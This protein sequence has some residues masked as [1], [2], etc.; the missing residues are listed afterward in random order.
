MFQR[1]I[2]LCHQ[3]DDHD[4]GDSKHL[5]NTG[6][7]QDYTVLYFRRLSLSYLP[8]WEPEIWQFKNK[9]N[10]CT[11]KKWKVKRLR[12]FILEYQNLVTRPFPWLTNYGFSVPGPFQNK[13]HQRGLISLHCS[14]SIWSWCKLLHM[15]QAQNATFWWLQNFSSSIW[16]MWNNM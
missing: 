15:H 6:L 3:G 11:R 7:L 16:L 12:I 4:D 1:C 5:W 14:H 9:L 10:R 2:S 13:V 8:M